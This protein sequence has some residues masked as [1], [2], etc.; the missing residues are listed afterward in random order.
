MWTHLYI[1]DIRELIIIIIMLWNA[2]HGQHI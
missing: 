1:S 2:K